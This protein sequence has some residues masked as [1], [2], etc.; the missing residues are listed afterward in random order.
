[1]RRVPS[2]WLKYTDVEK[3]Y[4]MSDWPQFVVDER[5]TAKDAKKKAAQLRKDLV[6]AGWVVA[7][8]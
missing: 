5:V 4:R 7:S 6:A 1:M 2:A 8:A 3:D